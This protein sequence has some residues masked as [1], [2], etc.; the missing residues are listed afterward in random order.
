[1]MGMPTV[2]E[3]FK[4]HFHEFYPLNNAEG[5]YGNHF[6]E[7]FNHLHWFG[8]FADRTHAENYS[9]FQKRVEKLYDVLGSNKSILF[10]YT[11]E[12]FLYYKELR[13]QEPEHYRALLDLDH[14]LSSHYPQLN[15]RILAIHTNT[16]HQDTGNVS[17]I[18]F[19][20]PHVSDNG[21]TH[22]EPFLSEYRESVTRLIRLWLWR[23]L[24]S[25]FRASIAKRPKKAISGEYRLSPN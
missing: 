14:F 16:V 12:S 19:E 4:N 23:S 15:Y 1:M 22:R 21:E 3:L 2:L 11:T 25:E 24:L 13:D 10:V 8:H 6:Y 20:C 9:T 18:T 17:N 5:D 7:E